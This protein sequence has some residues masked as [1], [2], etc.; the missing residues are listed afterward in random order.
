[1]KRIY[2]KIG[3]LGIVAISALVLASCSSVLDEQ[4]RSEYDPSFFQTET[5]IEGGL[6]SLYA[7][8]R[9]TYG[10]GYY[11]NIQETGTDEY[12][13]GQG[14]DANFKD[15]DLSGNG[16]LTASSS[17]SDVLWGNAFI[18]INTAS[19]VIE[20]A[21]QAGISE[22][23]ISEARFFRAFDYFRLVQ[24]FGGVPLDL[25]AGELA[26]NTSPARTSVRNTVP[27][28]YTKAIFPDLLTAIDNL[29]ENPRVTGGVTK[30]VARLVLGQAYLTY[31]Y[32]LQNRNDIPT[33]PE[34]SR[35]DPDGHDATWYFQQA[36]QLAQTG[37]SNPGPYALQ[38]TYYDVNLAQNDRNS[39]CMLYADHTESS[40]YYNGG[41]LTYG[42]GGAPDN[43]AS[44]MACW[45]YPLIQATGTNGSKFNPV[46]RECIQA[47]GR[48]WMRMAPTQEVFTKIF[49]DKTNDSRFDGTFTTV[50]R[51]NWNK[52]TQYSGATAINANGMSI[53]PGDA[54]LSFIETDENITYPS[55]GGDDAVG[56]GT[57]PGRADYVVNLLN[58]SRYKYP[59][60]WKIGP[61]RTDNGTGLGQPNAGSTRPFVI[62]KYSEFYFVAAEA[63]LQLGD[64]GTA[65]N[66]LNVIRGRAGKWRFSNAENAE[67][68]E[69]H[70]VEM[71]A[72][73]P[74]TITLD[75]ILDEESREYYGEGRRWFD[76]V[77]TQTWAD[78]AGTY[79]IA[80]AGVADHDPVTYTRTIPKEYYLRPIP[81]SQLDAL[82][83]SDEEKTAYQNPGYRD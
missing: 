60:L 38:D 27:E 73:T 18:Y 22:S 66:M 36:L 3:N 23:L 74:A 33:Y 16:S 11:Y 69:D 44:W 80:G 8:L 35:T 4:P 83:M 34:C 57:L 68:I 48:P 82:Q 30:N 45:N 43:F 17:R 5:G 40:E 39:E 10:Q 42:S 49:T 62:L 54:V 9:D 61:Y 7:H 81:Q 51:A 67:K 64:N 78:R 2:N 13:F 58:V 14:A 72:A 37:I 20:N 32:W 59:N 24:T 26:F 19:G 6:T 31:G 70:S 29:P 41:S 53:A 28:V 52:D 50:Y 55:D 25:G 12:T 63:A 77:R 46:R 1:M 47:L 71:Q 76:L 75:Y 21:A 56:G 79:T 15:A 65:R